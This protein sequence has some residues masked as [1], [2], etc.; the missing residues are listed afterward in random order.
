M[1]LPDKYN[2]TLPEVTTKSPET[3]RYTA[4]EMAKL[5]E[6]YLPLWNAKRFAEKPVK[7]KIEP[8][9]IK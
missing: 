5:C 1:T 7:R 9:E 2:L 6:R 3:P 8:F 4:S